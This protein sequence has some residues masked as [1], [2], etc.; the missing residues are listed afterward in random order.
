MHKDT[1]KFERDQFVR[2]EHEIIQRRQEEILNHIND[3]VN[4][5]MSKIEKRYHYLFEKLGTK[6]IDELKDKILNEVIPFDIHK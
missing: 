4:N 6:N 1:L 2:K 5:D 3:F